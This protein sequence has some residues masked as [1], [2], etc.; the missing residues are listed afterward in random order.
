[1]QDIEIYDELETMYKIYNYKCSICRFGDGELYHI[2]RS[3]PEYSSGGQHC[4]EEI[5]KKLIYILKSSNDKIL[6]GFS[7]YFCSEEFIKKNYNMKISKSTKNFI[8]KYKNKLKENYEFL[9]YKKMYSAEITRLYQLNNYSPIVEI[10][11]KIF[12][13]NDCVFIG[14][15][16]VITLIKDNEQRNKFKNI[17]FIPA[18]KN[19]AYDKYDE[20]MSE[21]F[22]ISDLQ[23]KLIL[24]SLGITATIMSFDLAEK[25]YWAIDIGHYFEILYKL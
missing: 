9:F 12:E 24:I 15:N 5:Q 23:N 10:F 1:M 6:I 13:E 14:N 3:N 2:F 4:N 11:N 18:P 22:S 20:I 19:N 7:G 16:D 8:V 25:G 21:I 17:E